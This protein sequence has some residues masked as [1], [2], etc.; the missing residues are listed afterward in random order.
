MEATDS[1]LDVTMS[2]AAPQ[3]QQNVEM[4]EA[5][6]VASNNAKGDTVEDVDDKDENLS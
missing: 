1:L 3:F 2:D 4:D 5:V 6:A